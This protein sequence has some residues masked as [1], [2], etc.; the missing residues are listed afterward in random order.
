MAANHSLLVKVLQ[1][2]EQALDEAR[3]DGLEPPTAAC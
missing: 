2:L 3:A 1:E